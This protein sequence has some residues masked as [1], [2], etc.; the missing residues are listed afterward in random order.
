MQIKQ[1]LMNENVA[2]YYVNGEAGLCT[3]WLIMNQSFKSLDPHTD[4]NIVWD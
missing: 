3:M 2:S 4:Y 1:Q